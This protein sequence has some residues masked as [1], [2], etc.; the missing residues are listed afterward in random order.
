MKCKIS[1]LVTY[2]SKHFFV[3]RLVV[4]LFCSGFVREK[5]IVPFKENETRLGNRN[6]KRFNEAMDEIRNKPTLCLEDEEIIDYLIATKR[7]RMGS[8]V[9]PEVKPAGA[10]FVS[11]DAEAIRVEQTDS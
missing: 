8:P 4:V 1:F 5:D 7:P 3:K 11:S 10:Q 9:M 6:R 2:V